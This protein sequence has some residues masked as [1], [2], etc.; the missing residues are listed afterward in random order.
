MGFFSSFAT[1][2]FF[3]WNLYSKLS[4]Y[5]SYLRPKKLKLKRTTFQGVNELAIFL[6]NFYLCGRYFLK[7][8]SGSLVLP[9]QMLSSRNGNI[10]FKT[11][12]E[13]AQA[14]GGSSGQAICC[15]SNL[16]KTP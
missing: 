2:G 9:N 5:L 15:K 6:L 8:Y 4:L 3:G 16:Q 13:G 11:R 12:M 14:L 10:S 7:A 1:L